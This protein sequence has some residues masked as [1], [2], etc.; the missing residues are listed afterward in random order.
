MHTPSLAPVNLWS[1][2]IRRARPFHP[3]IPLPPFSLF[4]FKTLRPL[5]THLPPWHL[6]VNSI[7]PLSILTPSVSL[8]VF[9]RPGLSHSS[10]SRPLAAVNLTADGL[11]FLARS[12]FLS[13]CVCVCVC[14]EREGVGSASRDTQAV[15]VWMKIVNA[16]CFLLLPLSLSNSLSL[17]LSLTLHFLPSPSSPP[18]SLAHS[19]F[20]LT[21]F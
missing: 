18:Y 20:P 19:F 21:L 13:V 6:F 3:C 14:R 8:L 7:P 16:L 4:Y 2:S 9:S 11:V 15:S 5:T 10:W 17:S 1:T 12:L